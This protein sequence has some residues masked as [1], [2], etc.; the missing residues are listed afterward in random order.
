MLEVEVVEAV[1]GVLVTG[2]VE[3][4]TDEV[5]VVVVVEGLVVLEGL[6][7]ANTP[8]TAA[9]TTM[10]TTMPT[11]AIIAIALCDIIRIRMAIQ[12]HSIKVFC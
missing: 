5:E 4:V 3:V 10:T 6:L 1:V 12:P 7:K 11:V 8:A 2:V 9:I